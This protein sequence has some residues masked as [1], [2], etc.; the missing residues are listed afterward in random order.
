MVE[1]DSMVC[2]TMV[3]VVESRRPVHLERDTIARM[4]LYLGGGRPLD[5]AGGDLFGEGVVGNI[6][7]GVCVGLEGRYCSC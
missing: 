3:L 2:G 7:S 6:C 5:F 4:P 1:F